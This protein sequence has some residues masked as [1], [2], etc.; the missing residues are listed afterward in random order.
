MAIRSRALDKRWS[1]LVLSALVL[2]PI[3][4]SLA[5]TP[6]SATPP[7]EEALVE[8]RRID[9][10]AQY[11]QGA[12]AYAAGHYKDAVDLFLAADRLA[13][14]APL[15][16]NIA[17]AYEKLD[18]GSGALRW[19][20][21]YLRRNPAATNAT[22]VRASI[23][24]LAGALAKKG[25][26][27]LSVLSSPDGAT[28][29]IDDQPIGVAPWTGELSPGKHHLLLTRRGY[30]DAVRDIE[31]LALEPLDVTVR[32]EQLSAPLA[33]SPSNAVPAAAPVSTAAGRG[34]FARGRR[35]GVLPWVSLG[36]GAGALGGA[37]TFELLRRS[38]ETDAKREN[39][40]LGYQDRLESEQSRQTAARVF[41]G[42]GGAFVVAGGVMLLLD[43][44]PKSATTS[45]GFI[46]VPQLCAV[47]ARS[48][49]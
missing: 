48:R 6:A 22:S 26:Q 14:S 24:T 41:L 18:D 27:Q 16:F 45:A 4:R 20:R 10:K 35:L 23:A 36:V 47:S 46:C 5:D 49:F 1:A 2:S 38:A 29:A 43:S 31:L 30:T 15:S 19:Y 33:S 9:A 39:T 40:Q 42:M 3:R 34:E 32:L 25:V 21:D 28:V 12:E 44:P 7:S 17:R 8:Q 37:L 13:P 11:Q